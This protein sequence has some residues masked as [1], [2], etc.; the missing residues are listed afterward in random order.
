M[1]KHA[2]AQ[3]AYIT[4]SYED[5]QVNLIVEDDGKGF[6]ADKLSNDFLQTGL[7]LRSVKERCDK[8][9]GG[10]DITS[11]EGQGTV[12]AF[13]VS[14]ITDVTI[15]KKESALQLPRYCNTDSSAR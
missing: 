12:I 7:G 15:Q 9:Q 8:L 3:Q 13:L 2:N 10:C 11:K 6:S 5:G 14:G 1:L 4:A